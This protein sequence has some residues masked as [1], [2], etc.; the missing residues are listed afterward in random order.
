[1]KGDSVFITATPEDIEQ[2]AKLNNFAFAGTTLAI[3]PCDP[4]TPPRSDRE[5]P[6]KET[7]QET[8]M[9]KERFKKV[10]SDRY[11][12]SL[13]LLNLSGL[14]QD[15]VLVELGKGNV[16][17]SK[18][19]PAL[20][21]ICDSLFK[22]WKEKRDS[23]V[24]VTLANNGLDKIQLVNDLAITLPHIKNLDLSNNLL[25]DLK[26]L[27]NWRWKFR[28]LENLVLSN[29]PL[30]TQEPNYNV[31]I[32]KWY[33]KLL[34]LNGI[35]VRTPEQVAALASA[36]NSPIPVSGGDF[37]DVSQVG[38]NFVKQFI[39]LYDT[40]RGALLSSFY[41]EQSVFS[42]ALNLSSPRNRE[43]STAIPAWTSYT[44]HSRN[45]VKLNH[46]SARMNRSHRGIAA[47]QSVWSDFPATKHPDLA[48]EFG[49]YMIE[50]R[51]Q[52][53]LPDPTGQIAGG[54]DG[55]LITIHGEFEEQNSTVTD[56]ALRSFSRTFVL[57]PGAPG[58][59]QIRVI[60]DMMTLRAHSPLAA[61]TQPL[62]Q[63]AVVS[64]S[65]AIPNNT[66]TNLTQEQQ[67]EMMARQLMER[68]MMNMEYA[69]LC[70]QH[71]GWDIEAA[72]RAFEENK[73]RFTP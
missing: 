69:G 20:M 23:I 9:L 6:K 10:L 31:E 73:V 22:D 13:K 32:M 29:N 58:G 37:R 47:I 38:E 21:V 12:A 5:G 61:L 50:C 43:H 68:T 66:N 8:Q 17:T 11:D 28:N 34:L 4:E 64:V 30:E 35:P 19:F 53:G 59:P 42:M 57:G 14:G 46:I 24:S 56:R 45:M 51:P 15:P 71:T 72:F 39:N 33:P 67:Q 27:Q 2:L 18:I 55:L 7:S 65:P 62:Q 36:A 60:S 70:L 16:N 40:N 48:T 25:P 63:P 26:S 41:D 54:V 44:K 52:P 3:E 1:M 49:K